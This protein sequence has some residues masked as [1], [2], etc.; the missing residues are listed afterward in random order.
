M[1]GAPGRILTTHV[2]S[3]I[4]PTELLALLEAKRDGNQVADQ[5]IADCTAKSVAAVVRQ[6]ADIGIDIV[7]DGE[8]GKSISWSRYILERLTGFQQRDRKPGD[9][10]FP[11][12]TYGKDRRDFAEFY[13]EYDPG[14]N[15]VSMTG[16]AVDGPIRYKG[17]AAL[18]QDIA[19]LKAAVKGVNVADVFMPA[20]APAS[21]AP[22]RKDEFYRSDEDYLVAVAEA[23]REE[24]K[25]IVAAGFILQIDDAYIAS[26]YDVI[27]PPGTMADFRKWARRRIDILNHALEGIPEERTRYHV[28]WG[29]WNGP[30][31]TDVPFKEIADLVLNVR[32][33][34]YALELANPRHEHEWRVWEEIK[35]PPGRVLVPGVISHQT[36][37]V[38]HPELVAERIE[39]LAHLVGRDNVIASTDCGFAQGPFVRRTHPSI[40][41]AK[42]NALVEGARLASGRLW[43]KQSRLAS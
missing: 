14:Q 25:A 37:V 18:Q 4:R 29:S 27:V 2:G 32:V 22:D 42:L 3:L 23:L 39:R 12:A 26:Y 35:L 8:F 33:G 31:T 5:V 38:E 24:Y 7:N 11:A 16:W 34:G 43:N 1:A 30:H 15:M 36:N 20:V 28:C 10:A 6:Q 40:M 19:A 21:V 41:W 9:R 13:A 17:A